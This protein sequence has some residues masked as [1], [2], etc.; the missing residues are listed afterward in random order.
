MPRSIDDIR[1]M[2]ER[3]G[4]DPVLPRGYG[5][6]FNDTA[7]PFYPGP[8]AGAAHRPDRLVVLR[9]VSRARRGHARA[10]PGRRPRARTCGSGRCPPTASTRWGDRGARGGRGEHGRRGS[11][12]GERRSGCRS[13]WSGPLPVAAGGHHRGRPALRARRLPL[14]GARAR[15]VAARPGSP[16]A[17]RCSRSAG[18]PCRSRPPPRG[19]GSC[20]CRSISSTTKSEQIRVD[21]PAPSTRHPLRGLGLGMEG[22]G[23]GQRRAAAE[24]FRSTPS[25]SCSRSAS[26]RGTTS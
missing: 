19:A 10:R 17:T 26:R 5:A 9:R 2:S 11:S 4:A 7:Y 14:V 15:T 24:R 25:T 13:R 1:Q 23:L 8:Q 3:F 6:D 12:R 18:R 20:P 22:D 16:R 21:A